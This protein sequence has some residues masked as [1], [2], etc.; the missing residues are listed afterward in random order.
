MSDSESERQ[1]LVFIYSLSQTAKTSLTPWTATTSFLTFSS[2]SSSPLSSSSLDLPKFQTYTL[3][4]PRRLV[5]QCQSASKNDLQFVLHDALDASGID[6]NNARAARENFCTQI[7]M[8]TTLEMQ[9]S[10]CNRG[11]DL[12]TTALQIAAEDHSLLSRSNLPFPVD[13]FVDRLDDL[14]MSYLPHH[15][16]SASPQD[17]I[18]NLESYLYVHKG[19]QRKNVTNQSEPRTLYL[20]S[21]LANRSGSALML[22]LIYSEVLKMLRLWDLFN[23]DVE[24]DFP[25]D[26]VT[27]P[28]G[29]DKKN[30]EMADQPYIMTSQSLLLEILRTQ[31]EA[32]WPFQHDNTKSLFLRASDACIKGP[33]TDKERKFEIESTEG[34]SDWS[35]H[36]VW[37]KRSNGDMRCALSGIYYFY[38][39]F[40]L[41]R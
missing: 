34:A 11:V 22:S 30:S 12:G 7:E 32:F 6:T 28:R 13:T 24:I 9:T 4:N 20:H 14:S 23:F 41:V 21:A 26:L 37:T 35:R 39:L 1:N 27:L 16:S 5:C 29:Y 33:S 2:S 18:G 17:F 25:H 10:I 19:F 8:F 15:N 36:E 38:F 3:S 40:F 31:K